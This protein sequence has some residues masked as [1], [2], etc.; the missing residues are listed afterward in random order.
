MIRRPPRST[1]LYSSAAS[2]VYKR[3]LHYILILANCLSWIFRFLHIVPGAL[4]PCI[5]A[6]AH[7]GKITPNGR[8]SWLAIHSIA[9]CRTELKTNLV[10]Y[11]QVREIG[12]DMECAPQSRQL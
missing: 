10:F 11:F 5:T 6:K 3:Q 7:P 2:D 4:H 1:P 8:G 12:W 9:S